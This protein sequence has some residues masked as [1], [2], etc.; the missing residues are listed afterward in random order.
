MVHYTATY[1]FT[2]S[3]N[4]YNIFDVFKKENKVNQYM[5]EL[6]AADKIIENM[7]HYDLALNLI[8]QC[9]K[10]NKITVYQCL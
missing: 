2:Q 5:T 1:E 9:K 8:E 10:K 4:T 6:E 3:Y 7:Q